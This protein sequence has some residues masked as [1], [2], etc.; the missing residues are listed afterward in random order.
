[1][2]LQADR[3]ENTTGGEHMNFLG[4]ILGAIFG[5]DALLCIAI[6]FF[7]VINLKRLTRR[8]GPEALVGGA[9]CGQGR[10][11]CVSVDAPTLNRSLSFDDGLNLFTDSINLTGK[12]SYPADCDKKPKY[13]GEVLL[14]CR[15]G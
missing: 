2:R 13:S 3:H 5:G 12:Y 4:V 14:S 9:P 8:Y 1:M 10:L 6:I 7:S 11:I 15:K